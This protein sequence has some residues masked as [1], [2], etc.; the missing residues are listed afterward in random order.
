MKLNYI[1]ALF[2]FVLLSSFKQTG[3][4][5]FKGG[6]TGLRSFISQNLIYPQY[7]RQNCIQGTIQVNFKLNKQGRVYE[8]N[9]QKGFG[10]DLDDEALRLLRLTSGKW[11][12]PANYDT[13]SVITVPI[14]FSLRETNCWSSASEMKKAIEAYKAQEL[15]S[16]AVVTYYDKKDEG[17]YAPE[18]EEKILALKEQL[19]YDDEYINDVISGAKK[20]LKQGDKEDACKDL[21]FIKKIGSDRADKLLAEHCR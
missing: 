4:P 17:G 14:N 16:D 6:A 10:I 11:N 18:D 15:L 3:D 9:V 13:A 21:R 1:P 2:L 7:S 5:V 12:I 8:S 20:K 19:G